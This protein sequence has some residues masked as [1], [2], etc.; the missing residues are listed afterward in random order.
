MP[1]PSTQWR[2]LDCPSDC[3]GVVFTVLEEHPDCT[4]VKATPCIHFPDQMPLPYRVTSTLTEERVQL[5][6]P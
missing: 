5:I 3:L 6:Q 1:K 4:Y 2:S